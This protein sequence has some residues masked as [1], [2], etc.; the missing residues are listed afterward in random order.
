MERIRSF[1]L[2]FISCILLANKTE[3]TLVEVR[4]LRVN[5]DCGNCRSIP[6]MEETPLLKKAT[7]PLCFDS[8]MIHAYSLDE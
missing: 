7:L 2:N 3:R 6:G 4:D 8:D 5:H 1:S